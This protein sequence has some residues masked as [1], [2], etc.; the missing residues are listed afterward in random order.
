M[1]CINKCPCKY[2]AIIKEIA[3]VKESRLKNSTTNVGHQ[4]L[5]INAI[6]VCEYVFAKGKLV[7]LACFFN[8]FKCSIFL[9]NF[10]SKVNSINKEP[11]VSLHLCRHQCFRKVFNLTTVKQF[12]NLIISCSPVSKQPL[13][14]FSNILWLFSNIL[15]YARLLKCSFVLWHNGWFILIF[16]IFLALEIKCHFCYL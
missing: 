9:E 15:L 13:W 8:F 6:N 2:S 10:Y 1:R 14:P 5:V 11:Y 7:L 12:Y 4:E 16:N 3:L